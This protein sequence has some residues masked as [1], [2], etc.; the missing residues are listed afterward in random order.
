MSAQT[1][2]TGIA[3]PGLGMQTFLGV[4]DFI[5]LGHTISTGAARMYGSSKFK[6]LGNF[7]GVFNSCC[8]NSLLKSVVQGVIC[9]LL[10]LIPVSVDLLM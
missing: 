10:A 8:A 7:H 5:S 2:I 1:S 9:S 4:I 3:S 6:V